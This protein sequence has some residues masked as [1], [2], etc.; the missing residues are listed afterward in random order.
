MAVNDRGKE[1][2]ESFDVIAQE[3]PT[4]PAPPV[5]SMLE[6]PKLIVVAIGEGRFASA[7]A[8]LPE[9]PFA[10]ED[11]RAVGRFLGAPDG[12]PRFQRPEVQA[13]VGPEATSG[14]VSEALKGSSTS[15]AG[16]E[17]GSGRAIPCFV[18]L[19]SHFLSFDK[20]RRRS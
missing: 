3:P 18:M 10:A 5:E 20:K 4:R 14:R 12:K 8:G 1:R 11:A 17:E 13:L 6:P 7:K 15:G 2:A 16:K 9:I 19:E